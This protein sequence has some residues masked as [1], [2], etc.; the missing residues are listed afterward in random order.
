MNAFMALV[1]NPN[2]GF[3]IGYVILFIYIKQ[4]KH[5]VSDIKDGMIWS[6][7]YN[8]DNKALSDK[9]ETNENEITR[10]RNGKK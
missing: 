1:N 7:T 8:A 5:D 9:I 2:V 10:L 3:V 4:L 6:D